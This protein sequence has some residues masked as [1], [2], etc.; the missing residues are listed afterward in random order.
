MQFGMRK[1]VCE[2][3][4]DLTEIDNDE[5]WRC[6]AC[7]RCPH[8]RPGDVKVI[9]LIVLATGHKSPVSPGLLMRCL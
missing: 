1:I 3:T 2:T 4:F 7:A 6:T 8:Y 5:I 9:E